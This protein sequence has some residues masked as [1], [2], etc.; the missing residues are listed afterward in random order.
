[1]P[2]LGA[3]AARTAGTPGLCRPIGLR[4]RKPINRWMHIN[5][6]RMAVNRVMAQPTLGQNQPRVDGLPADVGAYVEPLVAGF[7]AMYRF[8]IAQRSALLVADGP[9]PAFRGQFVRFLFRSN[10]LYMVLSA[11]A[12]RLFALAD[13]ADHSL[14]FELLARAFPIIDPTP[15]HWPI[16]AAER[17]ALLRGDVPFFGAY[18]DQAALVLENGER[19]TDYFVSP[20]YDA[21][22][23]KLRNLEEEDLAFQAS[24]IRAA[25]GVYADLLAQESDTAPA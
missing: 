20:S 3:G 10:H 25:I 9:L 8:L 4:S 14:V 11:A 6:D 18:T 22:L 17:D 7:S 1:L 19:I 24:L 21:M 13:G 2:D 5:T 12:M 23:E 15:A 16:L